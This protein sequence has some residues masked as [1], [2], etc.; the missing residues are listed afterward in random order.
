MGSNSGKIMDPA[1]Y[2]E[3][4]EE[5]KGLSRKNLISIVQSL[6][7]RRSRS[8][9]SGGRRTNIWPTNPRKNAV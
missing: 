7:G 3:E 5:E 1:E 6:Q 9:R 2:L 8:G 4:E